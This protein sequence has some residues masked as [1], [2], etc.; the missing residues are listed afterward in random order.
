MLDCYKSIKFCFRNYLIFHS[1]A[2]TCT[3]YRKDTS[4]RRGESLILL[5]RA[6]IR[7]SHGQFQLKDD[8]KFEN[9]K[10]NF[11]QMHINKFICHHFLLKKFRL[12]WIKAKGKSELLSQRNITVLFVL[13]NFEPT[14]LK[15][16]NFISLTCDFSLAFRTTSPKPIFLLEDGNVFL[17]IYFHCFSIQCYYGASKQ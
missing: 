8:F 7:P 15:G 3:N 16:I 14:N 10:I 11:M 1:F 12:T 4:L 17:S 5:N 2:L 13:L 6:L 9:K